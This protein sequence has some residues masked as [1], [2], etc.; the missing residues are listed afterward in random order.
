[1]KKYL[2]FLGIYG[3]LF[4]VLLT[5]FVFGRNEEF[6]AVKML[7]SLILFWIVVCGY[8]MHFYRDNFSRFFNNIK[9][10]FLLKFVLFSSIFVLVEEGIATGIN[11]YFYLN[12]GVSALTAS[13]NYFEVIFKHSLVALVPLF[14]VFGLYLKKYK[15]SPEKAFLIFG[16]VGVFAETTVGGLL[17]LLQAGMWIFVYGL[18]IYLPYYSFFKVSKN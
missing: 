13:T 3:I 7:W 10:K 4:Q 5:F 12:T 16:I 8:L 14:I 9:L 1:M 6:V 11:Y 15:P 17:S 18:M 2:V